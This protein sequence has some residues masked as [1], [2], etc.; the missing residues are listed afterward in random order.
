[1]GGGRRTR[2][3]HSVSCPL[4]ISTQSERFQQCYPILV[5]AKL[6]FK[7]KPCEKFSNS[8]LKNWLELNTDFKNKTIVWNKSDMGGGGLVALLKWT[9]FY[10][11]F[12]LGFYDES[13][14]KEGIKYIIHYIILKAI[15][16]CTYVAHQLV[17]VLRNI[18]L[19][20][21]E[22]DIKDI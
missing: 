10:L 6:V 22:F 21:A 19:C 15:F 11:C 20:L 3:G 18:D 9:H 13:Q 8:F 16:N 12:F 4:N 5:K 1:M 14:R 7:A 2:P 17:F